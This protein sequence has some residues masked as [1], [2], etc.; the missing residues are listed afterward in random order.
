MA[1]SSRKT[2]RSDREE[3]RKEARR[4]CFELSLGRLAL[5]SVALLLGLTWMFVFGV[6]IGRGL[7]LVDP[8][9]R[10]IKAAFMYFLGLGVEEQPVPDN[11]AETWESPE[12][13]LES[14]TYFQ[15]LTQMGNGNSIIQSLNQDRQD[16][17]EASPG[18]QKVVTRRERKTGE[19]T[20][21]S[22]TGAS[23]PILLPTMDPLA[24]HGEEPGKYYTLLVAS[25]KEADNA[26]KLVAQL[27]DKGYDA[28]VHALDLKD[29]GRWNRVLVGTFENRDA[30]LDFA[31]EFNRREQM[32]GLVI[33][34]SGA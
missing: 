21:A 10:G 13:M 20:Q 1:L 27:K 11:V 8:Q 22:G 31:V 18:E 17:K 19:D 25:L 9:D 32:Q 30:A 28:R 5:Y 15:D 6:L 29:S 16:G 2:S 26:A 12:K 4:Y 24:L 14:L 34:E 33:R 3:T 23:E 7:P